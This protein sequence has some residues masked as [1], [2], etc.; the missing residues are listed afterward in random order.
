MDT[1]PVVQEG[2]SPVMRHNSLNLNP[3]HLLRGF[4]VYVYVFNVKVLLHPEPDNQQQHLT[5]DPSEGG[6]PLR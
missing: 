6:E 5:S 1:R 4:E 3:Q 2:P